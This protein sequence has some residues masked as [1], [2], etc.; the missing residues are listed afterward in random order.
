VA[1][2]PKAGL[3][4]NEENR[5]KLWADLLP[6]PS[7]D[8][9]KYD[10]GHALIYAAPELTGATRL[11]ASACMRIGAGLVTV[12]ARHRADVYRASL[13][14]SIM[15]RH[16]HPGMVKNMSAVLVGPGGV[17]A[18]HA[19]IAFA[20]HDDCHHVIDADAIDVACHLKVA[21][22]KPWV[23]TPHQGEFDRVFPQLCG[24]REDR[25]S[26]A[27][28]LTGAIVVLKGS[29]TIIAGPGGE[30]VVS[31]HASP[32]LASAGTG[33]VLAGLITGLLAQSMPA[34]AACCV[35]VWVHAEAAKRFGPGLIA[36]DIPD[37]VPSI[38]TDLLAGQ[39]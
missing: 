8:G 5:P 9:H 15:V 26:E 32:Y 6:V 7:R 16:K 31:H 13:P 29:S 28:R 23:I 10:R 39:G 37:M 30:R 3:M 36:S 19:D 1:V 14:P 11:A 17:A 35:A 12:V 38:L 18:E 27:A 20:E 24:Q 25:A 33:D 4:M 2:S 34:F 22:G 21:Y